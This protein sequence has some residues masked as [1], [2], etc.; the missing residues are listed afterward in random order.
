M[1][2]KVYLNSFNNTINRKA[3]VSF[4]WQQEDRQSM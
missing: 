2:L 3:N 4:R 1:S